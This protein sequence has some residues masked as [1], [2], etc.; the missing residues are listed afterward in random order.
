[1]IERLKLR[2]GT[3]MVDVGRR[4]TGPARSHELLCL[5]AD[6]DESLLSGYALVGILTEG[7][8]ESLDDD[9]TFIELCRA[10]NEVL[11]TIKMV[12]EAEPEYETR[13]GHSDAS[14]DRYPGA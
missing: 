14:F 3:W 8:V 11:A 9:E 4:L 6:S 10:R 2:V 5:L 12:N 1:M 7:M 13:V